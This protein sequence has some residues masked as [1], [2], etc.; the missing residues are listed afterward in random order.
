[1]RDRDAERLDRQV[2]RISNELP[3]VA[4]GFLR[5]LRGSS[6]GWVRVP[7]GLLLI[8]FGVFGFLPVLDFGWCRSASCLIFFCCRRVVRE[9]E[10]VRRGEA[11]H[12]RDAE[13]LDRQVNQISNEL[14]QRSRAASC[15]GSEDHRRAGFG[16]GRAT[17]DHLRSFQFSSGVGFWMVPLGVLLLAQDIP[18][19]RR[20]ILRALLWLE[21]KWIKWKHRSKP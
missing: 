15:A 7:V 5:W 1:M 4:G 16:S 12:D 10:Y 14:P 9:P 17:S 13:Q 2:N 20:P 11:M 6:S 18:F 3:S 8:I 19:L 21:R